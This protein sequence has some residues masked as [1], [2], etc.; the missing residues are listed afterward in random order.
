MLHHSTATRAALLAMSLLSGCA[1]ADPADINTAAAN[2]PLTAASGAVLVGRFALGRTDMATAAD[3]LTRALAADPGNADLQRQAFDAALLAGRPDA[4]SL[5]VG[6][7]DDPA[8]MLVR[9]DTDIRAGDWRAAEL[10]FGSLPTQGLT[11]IL[12][13]L[14]QAWAQ[15]GAGA[16]D[17][18]LATLRPYIDSSRFRGLF[19]LHAALICDLAGRT[20]DAARLYRIALVEYGSLNLRLGRL[21]ASW[22]AR[23]GHDAEARATLH[24]TVQASPDLAIAEPALSQTVAMPQV[25]SPMDGV[26]EVYLAMAGSLQSQESADFAMLLLNQALALRP[27][28]S[29]ARLLASDLQAN[30]GQLAQAYAT[31]QAVPPTDPLTAVA[32]LRQA[33]ILERQ[34]RPGEARQLLG[35][36]AD[37]YPDSPDPVAALAGLQRASGDFAGA[38]ATFGQAIARVR[39]P[40]PQDWSL[41]YQQ[42]IAYDR[43]H[44]WPHAEADFV[45]ALDLAPNQPYVL[46]YL[47]YAWAEQG[48]NLPQARQMIERAVQERPNDGSIVDSLGW[49]LLQQGDYPAAVQTLERAVELQPEDPTVN[50]HLGDAYRATGRPLEAQTQWR[51]ALLLHP[52]PQDEIRLQAKLKDDAPAPAAT[53]TGAA[54]TAPH[55]E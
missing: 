36:L 2:R 30:S 20:A 14:L 28:F 43:A 19:A 5:A 24:A 15:Q 4:A 32:Q 10:K 21:V 25:T 11:Q 45:R 50:G 46:N 29:A 54:T 51:R 42:G 9:A 55:V 40:G 48:R 17:Q 49:V 12:R 13:P 52:E 6:L 35:H 44:D 34:D 37:A 53:T 38:A 16:T 18:A 26:A 8:A 33:R 27:D 7:A 23:N 3:N 39:Q 22:Q 31:L 41:Y 1:A 47:G